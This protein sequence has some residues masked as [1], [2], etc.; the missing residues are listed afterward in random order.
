MLLF[1]LL[2]L[3][4]EEGDFEGDFVIQVEDDFS[5][6]DNSV[7]TNFMTDKYVPHESNKVMVH[8]VEN[9]PKDEVSEGKSGVSKRSNSSK[10]YN[11]AVSDSGKGSNNERSVIEGKDVKK[12]NSVESLDIQGHDKTETEKSATEDR[13]C[14]KNCSVEEDGLGDSDNEIEEVLSETTDRTKADEIVDEE[15]F[16]FEEELKEIEEM[17]DNCHLEQEDYEKGKR[18]SFSTDDVSH[19]TKGSQK[20][21]MAQDSEQSGTKTEFSEKDSKMRESIIGN[22]Q[23]HRQDAEENSSIKSDVSEKTSE[24]KTE[25]SEEMS[26]VNTDIS[27]KSSNTKSEDLATDTS[28]KINVSEKNHSIRSV[29]SD[30]TK[31]TE[32]EVLDKQNDRETETVDTA[33]AEAGNSPDDLKVQGEL[34]VNTCGTFDVVTLCMMYVLQSFHQILSFVIQQTIATIKMQSGIIYF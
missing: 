28:R 3:L 16:D 8:S 21:H 18:E 15:V 12:L 24:I 11:S 6:A 5:K 26:C 4:D 29:S 32:A 10:G 9:Q 20:E 22:N 2:P 34:Y 25:V 30:K 33:P 14:P 23:I 17:L 13:N 7:R 1:F 19:G 27:G 31:S